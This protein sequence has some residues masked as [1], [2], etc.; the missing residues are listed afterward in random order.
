MDIRSR[1]F[2]L[3]DLKYKEFA[4]KLTKTKYP[5]I[6]VR[7]PCLK[8][9]AKE[10]KGENLSFFDEKYFEEIMLEGLCIGY[11]KNID[12]VIYKLEVFITKIDDWSVCDSCCA[13]LKITKKN[14]EKMWKFITRYKNSNNEFEVRF[15]IVMMMDYYLE[16]E[17]INEIFDII[18]NISCDFYYSNMA[19]SWLLATALAKLEKETLKYLKKAK[20][21]DFIYNKAI[22][23]S[24]DS[25]RIGNELKE[26]LRKI[27]R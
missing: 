16:N 11:L 13:N 10:L 23:K 6:G 25:H 9:M 27:K 4:S 17:Y 1:L 5:F 3:E 26:Y 2:E 7:I 8:K 20:V 18:D 24:C 22:S 19:I 21:N 12:S 14:K 15:M